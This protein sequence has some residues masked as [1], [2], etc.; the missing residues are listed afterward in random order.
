MPSLYNI[1]DKLTPLFKQTELVDFGQPIHCSCMKVNS[2]QMDNQTVMA[3]ILTTILHTP[4][5]GTK[6]N[7]MELVGT[8]LTKKLQQDKHYPT[9]YAP[10]KINKIKQRTSNAVVVPLTL[11]GTKAN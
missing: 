6:V 1:L 8:Q 3:D 10:T 4:A 7:L 5:T 9:N 11:T 2:E